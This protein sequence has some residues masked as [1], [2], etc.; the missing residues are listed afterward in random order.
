MYPQL[1]PS[2]PTSQYQADLDLLQLDLHANFV[3]GAHYPQDGR[4]LDMCDQRGILVWNEALAW[5]NQPPVLTNTSFMAAELG[6]ARAM[7]ASAAN[8]PSILLW[9]F[10][11]EGVSNDP[12][13][14]PSYAA[15]AETFRA[16]RSR[17][18]TWASNRKRNDLGYKYADVISFNSYPGWYGGDADS[19]VPSWEADA[20]WVASEWPSKP[21]IISETGAGGVAGNRSD[22]L[23]RWSEEYQALVDG[24]D[25]Q[26]AV[27]SSQIAGLALW[28]FTDIKVDQLNSS[29]GRPG[30]INNK[31]VFDQYRRPKLAAQRVA[32][33]FSQV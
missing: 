6:T 11:N 14:T 8:H 1:G 31:G 4:F 16:D 28:Q 20:A 2:L 18:V 3:R 22:N 24:L 30:G 10:F 9:G 7:L 33:I 23:S 13:S 15:M 21:F 19:V 12:A 5:G 25:A 29:A 17:L 32:E 27:N 26:V